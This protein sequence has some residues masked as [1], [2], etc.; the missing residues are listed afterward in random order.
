MDDSLTLRIRLT[1]SGFRMYHQ[2]ANYSVFIFQIG[3]LSV[4]TIFNDY[5][6]LWIKDFLM[7]PQVR[8]TNVQFLV[9]FSAPYF[10]VRKMSWHAVYSS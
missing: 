3:H 2:G 1:G 10:T 6:F 8:C 7:V 5:S 4:L 9:N